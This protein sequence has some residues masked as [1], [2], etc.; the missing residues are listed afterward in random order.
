MIS[1]SYFLSGFSLEKAKTLCPLCILSKSFS[2]TFN[3]KWV[4][5]VF[6]TSKTNYVHAGNKPGAKV[7][8]RIRAQHGTT[9]S[10]PS[11]EAV[12]NG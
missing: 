12:I 11:N 8:Y 9:L 4:S 3:T 7:T 10:L 2:K 1:A 6:T 5:S